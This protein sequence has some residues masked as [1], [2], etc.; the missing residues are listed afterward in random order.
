MPVPLVPLLSRPAAASDQA[1]LG[2][3]ERCQPVYTILCCGQHASRLIP[4][5]G[6]AREP[7]VQVEVAAIQPQAA[8]QPFSI[9]NELELRFFQ[10]RVKGKAFGKAGGKA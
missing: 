10:R 1:S 7:T 4:P 8:Q 2:K 3:T 5:C 9:F 6:D